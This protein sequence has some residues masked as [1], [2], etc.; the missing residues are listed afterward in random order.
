M[1][2]IWGRIPIPHEDRNS[3]DAANPDPD[4]DPDLH[5]IGI[6]MEIRIRIGINTMPIHN[7]ARNWKL[8]S[9]F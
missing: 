6:I 2:K 5:W 8:G 7:T 4:L 1:C 9:F 3:F